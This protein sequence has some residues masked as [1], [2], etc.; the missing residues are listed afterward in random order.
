MHRLCHGLF[1][2]DSCGGGAAPGGAAPVPPSGRPV[3][4][5][6]RVRLIDFVTAVTG[7]VV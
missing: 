4:I 5:V 6:G 1:L 2:P 7:A 3:R